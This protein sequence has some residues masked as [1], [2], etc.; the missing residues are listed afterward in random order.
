MAT[1][2]AY[3]DTVDCIEKLA[4]FINNTY[5]GISGSPVADP[6][7]DTGNSRGSGTGLAVTDDDVK[8][9]N[10]PKITFAVD[11]LGRERV[12]G[13]KS[14]YRE[15]FRHNVLIIYECHRNHIWTYNGTEYKGKKQCIKYLQYLGDK[16]KA[17]SGSFDEFNELVIGP[18]S[19]VAPN[20][21][22]HTYR[23]FM[24][25]KVDSYGKVG[26]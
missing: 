22:T 4:E 2:L 21:R 6:Y 24:P 26:E 10:Y 20:E 14:V 19:N 13:G 23:A 12:G 1:N 8:V 11:D 18:P 3:L 16:F 15:R 5:S 7:E 9:A 17:Y 25:I